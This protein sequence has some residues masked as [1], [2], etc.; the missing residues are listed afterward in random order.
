[1][2]L[3][4]SICYWRERSRGM[5]FVSERLDS[6]LKR[7]VEATLVPSTPLLGCFLSCTEQ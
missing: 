2:R 5:E 6:T 7:P 1:M 4:G 3:V